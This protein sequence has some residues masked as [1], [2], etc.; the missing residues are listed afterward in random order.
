V[1]FVT[2]SDR[3]GLRPLPATVSIREGFAIARDDLELGR[4][5]V[6]LP[7]YY[8]AFIDS[9]RVAAR[10]SSNRAVV[11]HVLDW[12][13]VDIFKRFD[14]H[15]LEPPTPH[16]SDEQARQ[17]ITRY[18]MGLADWLRL[19]AELD[20]AMKLDPDDPDEIRA[21]Q[22]HMRVYAVERKLIDDRLA[23]EVEAHRA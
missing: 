4:L 20:A 8:R 19:Q 9:V 1:C 5:E 7:A 6:Q 2:L 23:A 21:W 22:Q 14:G 3:E 15:P 12:Y 17:A 11:E 13:V 18:E 10:L 16:I